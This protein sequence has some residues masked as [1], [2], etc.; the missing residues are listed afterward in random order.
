[1]TNLFS[2]K[3]A[4][5]HGAK[6]MTEGQTCVMTTPAGGTL[7]AKVAPEFHGLYG[8]RANYLMS[9][10]PKFSYMA[11]TTSEDTAFISKVGE[12]PEQ[13]AD[14]GCLE[15]SLTQTCPVFA[16]PRMLLSDFSAVCAR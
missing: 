7:T 10:T 16:G 11:A 12:T 4:A 6:F 8:F 5:S 15:N 1:M 14:A 2:V 9:S 13:R 3:V